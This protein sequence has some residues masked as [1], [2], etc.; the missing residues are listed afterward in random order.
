MPQLSPGYASLCPGCG[1]L[2]YTQLSYLRN[3]E[4]GIIIN[5]QSASLILEADWERSRKRYKNNIMIKNTKKGFTLIEIL[6]V[7]A[8]IAI[9]ASVVLIGLGPTQQKGRDAR[10]LS[11]LRE[12]QTGIELYYSHCGVYPNPGPTVAGCAAASTGPIVSGGL[13][14]ALTGGGYAT[15]VPDDPT[16]SKHYTYTVNAAATSYTLSATLEDAGNPAL[17]G[18]ATPQNGVTCTGSTYCVSL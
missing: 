6:I 4:Y 8:I 13:A 5:K 9:L 11:D 10:R 2:G 12:L 17:V 14:A 7:V 16:T 18:Q 15:N 1:I 3:A